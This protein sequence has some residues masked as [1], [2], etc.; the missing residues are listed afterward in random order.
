MG[1]CVLQEPG[2]LPGGGIAPF[3][4]WGKE[5]QV[6]VKTTPSSLSISMCSA[7]ELV[8]GTLGCRLHTKTNGG[9]SSSPPYAAGLGGGRGGEELS[10]DLTCPSSQLTAD[11]RPRAGRVVLSPQQSPRALWSKLRND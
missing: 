8:P 2:R 1:E 6:S 10:V 3:P 11:T 7:S 5:S 9:K 4:H